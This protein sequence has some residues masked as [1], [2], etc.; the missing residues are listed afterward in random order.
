MNLLV[1]IDENYIGPLR[2]ML[3]SLLLSNPAEHF[4]V[5]LAHRAMTSDQLASVC[6]G[7]D[8][9]YLSLHPIQVSDQQLIGAPVEKRYPREMYYRLFAARYLPDS[10]DRILYLDPD[11]VVLGPVRP[12]YKID[13]DGHWFAAASHV[14]QVVQ[15][16]NELRL[17]IPSGGAYVNSGVLLMDLAALRAE[18]DAGQVLSYIRENRFRMVLPDQDVL[19]AL[20]YDRILQLNPLIYNLSE[21]YLLHH[22]FDLS[23]QPVDLDWIRSNTVFIHY[24]GRNKP[25][26]EGYLGILGRFYQEFAQQLPSHLD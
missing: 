14:H 21:K 5:Y 23:A 25:W 3:C 26:R 7:F 19:N 17:N 2:V 10:L 15:R 12:L 1:T 13:L 6:E 18:Q 22:N 8:S 20:Y 24:C 16:L 4:S 11:L 9:K